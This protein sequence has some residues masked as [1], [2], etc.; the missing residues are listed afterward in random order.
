MCG[1]VGAPGALL[2][3]ANAV[4][5]QC[6]AALGGDGDAQVRLGAASGQV[7]AEFPGGI[8]RRTAERFGVSAVSRIGG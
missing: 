8:K 6:I 5:E 7:S 4:P 3:L 2:A 1:A